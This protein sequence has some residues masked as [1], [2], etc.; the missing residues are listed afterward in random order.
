MGPLSGSKSRFAR[1]PTLRS[2]FSGVTSESLIIIFKRGAAP[3]AQELI[4]PR[5]KQNDLPLR[6]RD[7]NIDLI[8]FPAK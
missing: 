7:V 8:L 3:S 2:I 1:L 4:A 6:S 5:F